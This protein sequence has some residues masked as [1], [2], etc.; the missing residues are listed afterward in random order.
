LT[1]LM[2]R[3]GLT[4]YLHA[5]M[6][7]YREQLLVGFIDLDGFKSVNDD[8]DHA[9]GDRVLASIAERLRRAFRSDDVVARYGGDEFVV[10][11]KTQVG[12]SDGVIHSAVERALA[13]PVVWD[14]GSWNAK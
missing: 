6:T 5:A 4:A 7:E 3:E 2:N 8:F 13:E 11:C 14:G 12:A 9:V 10:V 1:G